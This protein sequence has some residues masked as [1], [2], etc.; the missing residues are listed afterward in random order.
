[1]LKGQPIGQLDV[2]KDQVRMGIV[3]EP[4]N[5]LVHGWEHGGA[6]HALLLQSSSQPSGGR[7]FILYGDWLHL[8]WFSRFNSL[9][10]GCT[11]STGPMH[12][13]P[14]SSMGPRYGF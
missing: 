4:F 14:K 12:R 13:V 5:G 9:E 2:Q 6:L 11:P 3:L 7:C 1:N 10:G 8:H